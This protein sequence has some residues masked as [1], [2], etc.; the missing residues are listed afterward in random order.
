MI[1]GQLDSGMWIWTT[2]GRMRFP[3]LMWETEHSTD[4][5]CCQ[6]CWL[7]LQTQ[8]H[9]TLL[10]LFCS[11]PSMFSNMPAFRLPPTITSSEPSDFFQFHPPL[12]QNHCSFSRFLKQSTSGTLPCSI[13]ASLRNIIF[14]SMFPESFIFFEIESYS[15]GFTIL[16]GDAMLI[17]YPFNISVK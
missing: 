3:G 2:N 9:V 6:L 17:T 13:P 4:P 12:S 11:V 16:V 10:L 14:S 7:I 1:V 5:L 8:A 15:W